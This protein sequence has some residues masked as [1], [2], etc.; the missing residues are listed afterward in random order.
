M[1]TYRNTLASSSASLERIMLSMA[2]RIMSLFFSEKVGHC[3]I[4]FSNVSDMIA[5]SMFRNVICV[6]KVE[7]KKIR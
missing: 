5:I 3:S 7:N 4:T 2:A 6:M 1:M